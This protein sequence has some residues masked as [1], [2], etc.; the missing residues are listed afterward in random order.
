MALFHPYRPGEETGEG[1]TPA[2]GG[3]SVFG[4]GKGPHASASPATPA[5]VLTHTSRCPNCEITIHTHGTPPPSVCPY[6]RRAL[7][8]DAV[9]QPLANAIPPPPDSEVAARRHALYHR[10]HA[11]F[12]TIIAL[13]AIFLLAW[14]V[15]GQW[16]GIDENFYYQPFVSV[17]S[18]IA[19]LFVITRFLFAAFYHAPADSGFEPTVTVL[20]PCFNEGAAIRTTIERIFASRYNL[21]KLEVVCVNDG[22]SDDSL[23]HMLAAQTLHPNLVVV[24]FEHNRGLCH[25][26][27]IG[28]FL[29]RG[30]FMVCVDSDTFVFPGSL[31]KLVQGFVDPTVGGIS[32]HCD[33]ENANVNLL[34]RLQDV[35]DYFSYKIMTAA[36]SIFGTVS[37]LPGC[38]SAYRR[39]CVLAVMDKWLNATVLGE[40][41]NFAD[42]RSLTN[43][44]LKDY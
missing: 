21:D 20:V 40:H 27:G 33:I 1:P 29:A 43:Q 38:F 41:G 39:T 34:P 8:Q 16:K 19:G 13:V 26:W 28:T 35:R 12:V 36:E 23:A 5:T 10:P 32:G 25:A 15:Y 24:N 22:S 6:C 3:S 31:N 7:V 37:C 18:V 11:V 42:D 9:N 44:I 4:G 30:E 14:A 17:Y 2:R